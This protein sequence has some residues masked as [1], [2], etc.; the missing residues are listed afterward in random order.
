[1]TNLLKG[2]PVIAGLAILLCGL[3]AA[4]RLP[5]Y[6]GYFI[7]WYA[8]DSGGYFY[9]AYRMAGGHLP[10]FSIRTPGYPIFLFAVLGLTGSIT[11]VIVLQQLATLIAG[12]TLYAAFVRANRWLALP[13]AVGI[14]GLFCAGDIVMYESYL[15]PEALY[16]AS[17]VGV[18]AAVIYAVTTRE[19]I[20]FVIASVL[21]AVT[22]LL[23]PAGMF[24]I[25]VFVSLA[26][27]LAW[28]RYP[29]R[30][31]VAFC[32]PFPAVLFV[33]A[34]YNLAT[35]GQFTISPW[36][37]AN[38]IAATSTFWEDSTGYPPEMR[39]AIAEM[40]AL[41]TPEDR[42]IL[43]TSWDPR[44]LFPIYDKYYNAS[45][46]RVLGRHVRPDPGDKR[47]NA[48]FKAVAFDAIRAHPDQY[49]K[50]VLTN[51]YEFFYAAPN[52]YYWF[53][54]YIE[55]RYEQI[56]VRPQTAPITDDPGIRAYL[57]REFSHPA[58]LPAFSAGSQDGEHMVSVHNNGPLRLHRYLSAELF[59]WLFN[60]EV[61]FWMF[62]L[63]V[64]AL[65]VGLMRA[66]LPVAAPSAVLA[67]ATA[68]LMLI[69]AGLVVSLVELGIARYAAP[70]HF[71]YF[72]ALPFLIWLVAQ[73]C[74]A[75]RISQLGDRF[76]STTVK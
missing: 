22:I 70:T 1:M 5:L 6:A 55:N 67:A 56:Y 29:R 47:A 57:L 75:D 48:L 39:A 66:R 7:P 13:A 35:I 62:A 26:T 15:G 38:L 31:L 72:L 23:K 11:A 52:A 14:A 20:A 25:V 40:H 71:I 51:L 74:S 76:A 32:V 46:H 37:S 18:A 21:M 17:I 49:F 64:L 54:Y 60:A 44:R 45:V 12:L 63:L 16:T 34:A 19:R 4:G 28:A 50:F 58:P 43:S 65:P 30:A 24:L 36:G 3:F 69:G 8:P 61:W 33:L 10:V 41:V 73:W 53:G 9:E 2:V 68:A 27:G 42:L 59:P